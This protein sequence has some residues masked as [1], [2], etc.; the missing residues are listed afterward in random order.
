MAF[1][2]VDFVRDIGGWAA[3]GPTSYQA[4]IAGPVGLFKLAFELDA[5][6]R[7]ASVNAAS[8]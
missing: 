1:V 7:L 2:F 8:A 5:A 6:P 3:G 4:R